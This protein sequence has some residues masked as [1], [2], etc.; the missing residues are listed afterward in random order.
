MAKILRYKVN[1]SMKKALFIR[2]GSPCN[3]IEIKIGK[4][5]DKQDAEQIMTSINDGRF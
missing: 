1:R 4:T 5:F 2:N 3:I